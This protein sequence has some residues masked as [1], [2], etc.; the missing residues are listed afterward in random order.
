MWRE[1]GGP[2]PSR[3]QHLSDLSKDT[4]YSSQGFGRS[5]LSFRI[6]MHGELYNV[7]ITAPALPLRGIPPFSQIPKS[8][9]G[10]HQSFLSSLS[11]KK[12][13][14]WS[15]TF[16]LFFFPSSLPPEKKP[17]CKHSLYYSLKF[18]PE[19]TRPS[20][21]GEVKGQQ[22]GERKASKNHTTRLIGEHK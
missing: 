21:V 15:Y 2:P 18:S 7:R 17:K 20:I 19:I 5:T 11:L 13:K 22:N 4:A 1:V 12:G 9:K 10:S 6:L 14:L 8:A 16:E 3:E